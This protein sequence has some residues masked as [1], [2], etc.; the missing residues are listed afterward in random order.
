MASIHRKNEPS[1]TTSSSKKPILRVA[2]KA[3]N[4]C[5]TRSMPVHT[6]RRSRRTKRRG[7]LILGA[8]DDEIDRLR[9]LAMENRRGVNVY[10]TE[11]TTPKPLNRGS[12]GEKLLRAWRPSAA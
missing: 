5:A 12:A 2:A 11:L 7:N 3:N 1:S 9:R 8:D 4:S 10:G 6:P